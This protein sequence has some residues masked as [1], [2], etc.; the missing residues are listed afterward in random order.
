MTQYTLIK[1]DGRTEPF[2]TSKI[3]AA[4]CR[5]LA[6]I[7][8]RLPDHTKFA[9]SLASA[10]VHRLEFNSDGFVHVNAVHD[11]VELQLL[12]NG[13][14]EAARAYMRY[15]E[16]KRQAKGRPIPVDV[17]EAFELSS[18]YFKD[19]IAEFQF[20]DKYARYNHELG[21][22]ETWP[23][24]VDRVVDFLDELAAQYRLISADALA[25]IKQSMLEFRVM[26]S[27]RLLAMAGEAGRRNNISL[28]N[29][30]FQGIDHPYA[31]VETLLILMAGTGKGYS[32]EHKFIDKLP[33]VGTGDGPPDHIMDGG[34]GAPINFNVESFRFDGEFATHTVDDSTKGWGNALTV[35]LIHW[36]NGLDKLTFDFS[37]VRNAGVPLKIKGGTASGPAPLRRML[38]FVRDRILS[39]RGQRLSSLDVHDIQCVIADCVVSG[40]VRR[41]AMIA[42]FDFDDLEMRNCKSGNWWLTAP[43]RANANNSAVLPDREFTFG[44][45]QSMMVAMDDGKSGEPGLFSRRNS[46]SMMPDRRRRK[47]SDSQLE[48]IGTNPCGEIV[49]LHKEFCNLSIAVARPGQTYTELAD[50]V[51]L[52]TIIGTI[53]STATHFPGLR[54][55]WKAN[56]EAERLLGVDITGQ[57]DVT[58]AQYFPIERS[59]DD[60]PGLGDSTMDALRLLTIYTNQIWA[61]YF[62]IEQSAATTTCKPGGNSS[63]KLSCSSGMNRRWSPY[64]IRRVIVGANTPI[65]KVLKAARVPMEPYKD[66]YQA[67]FPMRTPSEN[68]PTTRERCA[69]A[70]CSY[71]KRLKLNYTEHNP[72]CTIT[73]RPDEFDELVVWLFENQDIVGGMAFLPASDYSYDNAPNEEIT[74]EEYQ[75]LLA[76]FPNVDYSALY[77]FELTD[78]TT[79]AR[80]L[81]CSAGTCEL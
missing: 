44:E 16:E 14:T 5:C 51:E 77:A 25:R 65:F 35:G 23:E 47:L 46:I 67:I 41:S 22:R 72:S 62:G 45:I 32:V 50:A 40:G 57:M 78:E 52:A 1:T 56:C 49:L 53:Q 70:Q 55:Q 71:W 60:A 3:S 37:K 64:Q 74:R 6:A 80:E 19:P 31:F 34:S 81:A 42:L 26:P 33:A 66:G 12:T 11:E 10:T 36:F 61:E 29:C 2:E 30:A 73:Y 48:T 58:A 43:W 17:R 21:R 24:A 68:S 28:Y 38:N 18:Q 27:M 15:R 59:D 8:S 69:I 9:T 63:L 4:V 75:K 13:E 76:E 20:F 79:S 39:R 54:P 7:D